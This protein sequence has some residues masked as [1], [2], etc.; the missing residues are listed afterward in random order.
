MVERRTEGEGEGIREKKGTEKKG[1][2]VEADIGK[3]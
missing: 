2:V 3:E 1:D